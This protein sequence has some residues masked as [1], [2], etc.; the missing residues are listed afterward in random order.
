MKMKR[1]ERYINHWRCIS[2]PEEVIQ[3]GCLCIKLSSN[4]FFLHHETDMCNMLRN[5]GINMM[6]KN[7]YSET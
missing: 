1:M 6:G 3:I 7:M 5:K 2:T 4:S